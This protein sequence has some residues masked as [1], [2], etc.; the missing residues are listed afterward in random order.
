MRPVPSRQLFLPVIVFGSVAISAATIAVLALAGA[1]ADA[2]RHLGLGFG[3]VGIAI[4]LAWFFFG[5]D[6]QGLPTALAGLVTWIATG[7][8]ALS[9]WAGAI[10][11]AVF[12]LWAIVWLPA[13][14]RT[15]HLRIEVEISRDPATVFAF[16]S[17]MRNYLRYM[18]AVESVEQVGEGTIAAG[19]RFRA[20]GRFEKEELDEQFEVTEY[21]P[22]RRF[23]WRS[24]DDPEDEIETMTFAAQNGSTRVTQ[25]LV[26]DVSYA[27]AL[28]GV[29]LLL[30]ISRWMTSGFR[31]KSWARMKQILETGASA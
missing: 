11:L 22:P 17:D 4:G 29:A 7:V 14:T 5:S 25:E 6:E 16:A 26:D 20:R 9:V 21:D 2:F 3:V 10:I 27:S 8:A 23:G 12:A 15:V 1:P 18:P 13:R 31:R 19:T 24:A 30:P 28:I